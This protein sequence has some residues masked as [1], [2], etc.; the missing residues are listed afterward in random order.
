MLFETKKNRLKYFTR[1]LYCLHY[2]SEA[3]IRESWTV[4]ITDLFADIS[5]YQID[6][7]EISRYPLTSFW[8]YW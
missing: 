7:I 5:I 8:L 2:K 6:Y 1:N 4:W 3:E